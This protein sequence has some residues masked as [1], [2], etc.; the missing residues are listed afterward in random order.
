MS[1]PK[2]L[3]GSFRGLRIWGAILTIVLFFTPVA[4][5]GC[6]EG[7][8]SHSSEKD[9]VG[10]NDRHKDHDDD[11]DDKDEHDHDGPSLAPVMG[12]LQRF[13]H[14]LGYAVQAKNQPLAEF[15]LHEIEEASEEIQENIQEYDGFPVGDLAKAMLDPAIQKLDEKVDAG[16]WD[17]ATAEYEKLIKT[18]NA[19][20][21]QTDHGV[22]VITV[23]EQ[24]SPFNQNFAPAEPA[25]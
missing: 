6:G 24:P 7:S 14:K 25:K 16:S 20:H 17:E 12:D 5:T 3:R 21:M 15:Y 8:S 23:P 2:N 10:N 1:L 4:L 13:S 18:C 19:C 9:H 22:I 11:E